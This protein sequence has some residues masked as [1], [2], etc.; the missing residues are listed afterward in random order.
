MPE[1]QPEQETVFLVHAASDGERVS[2][3]Y[4]VRLTFELVEED[5]QWCGHCVELGTAAFADTREQARV[6]LTEA[7][8]LQLA[9]VEK[10]NEIGQYLRHNEVPVFP[11]DI[12]ALESKGFAE[13]IPAP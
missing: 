8:E 7:T 12:P 4:F 9:E 11:I 10:L 1:T 2:P 5:G 3:D 13:T 6:E